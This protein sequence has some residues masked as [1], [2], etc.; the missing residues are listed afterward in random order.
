MNE[1]KKPLNIALIGVGNQGRKHFD[2]ISALEKKGIVNLVG[3][4]DVSKD[5]CSSDFKRP[6]FI[7]YKDLF[8]KTNP[9]VVIISTP[10]Y[11]HKQIAFDALRRNIHVVKEKPLAIDY[12]EAQELCKVAK[13]NHRKI[14]TL[15]QRFYSPNFVLAK[16][17]ISRLG[18]PKKFSYRF[19][20]DDKVKSWRWDLKKAG[21]GSWLCMGWHAVSTV[22]WLIGEISLIALDWKVNGRRNWAYK[23]DHSSLAK[24]IAGEDIIGSLFLSCAYPRKEETLKIVFPTKSLYLSRG[25]IKI[26]DSKN[27]KLLEKYENLPDEREI[28]LNQM[29]K[30]LE[31]IENG[32]YTE[33]EDLKTMAVI[34]AGVKSLKLGSLPVEL[35][36]GEKNYNSYSANNYVSL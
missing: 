3:V 21:G 26:Y 12:R 10:N 22:R 5:I 15:Q 23:T 29:E 33:T 20:L 4:C 6:L 9:E 7:N 34:E 27:K 25:I 31:D 32:H 14:I 36:N 18:K 19:T 2:A 8:D 17:I 24:V 16:N 35:K 1:G 30:V 28:Y 11:L 13:E